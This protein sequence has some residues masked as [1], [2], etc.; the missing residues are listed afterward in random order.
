VLRKW[1][2]ANFKS[3]NARTELDLAPITVLAG[4][5][6]SGKSTII[7]SILLLKQ[8]I[9]YVPTTR[10]IGLNGP[11]LKLGRFDDI[12][13]ISSRDNSVQLSW[14]IDDISKYRPGG[15]ALESYLNAFGEFSLQ[16]ASFSISFG[17]DSGASSEGEELTV[18]RSSA[19]LRQL[20]PAL[21]STQLNLT[22]LSVEENKVVSHSSDISL[23]R[24][25]PRGETALNPINDS[26]IAQARRSLAFYVDHLDDS[27]RNELLQQRPE[28]RIVGA[29]SR[30]FFP[31]QVG[32]VYNKNKDLARKLAASISSLQASSVY[33]YDGEV[34]KAVVPAAFTQFVIS[35]IQ[36]SIVSQDNPSVLGSGGYTSDRARALLEAFDIRDMTIMELLESLH[37]VTRRID[38]R[39]RTLI[40]NAL[41]E[42]QEELE[43]KFLELASLGAETGLDLNLPGAILHSVEQATTFFRHSI[44]YLGPLRDEP[45]PVYPLEALVNPTDV[46][47]RG[48]HT[49]AVLDLHRDRQ[50]RYIRSADVHNPIDA[51]ERLATLHAAVVDWLSYLGVAESVRTTDLGKIGHQLQVR[52]GDN[53]K[54]HDLTNVG[55]G[56]SQLLPI[57]VMALLAPSPSFLIFEQP[58]LHLHPKV[59][60]RLADFFLSLGLSGR[61]CLLETH[62]EYL[63]ERLR[64]RIAEADADSLKDKIM[65]YFTEKKAGN[66]TCIPVEL[67]RYGAIRNWPTDFFDQ[68][69]TETEQL[70]T[71]AQRKLD[72]ER[73]KGAEKR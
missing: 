52:T 62:S 59:Q 26:V 28:S 45:R 46:G 61:Q 65:I 13:N 73:E 21:Q 42:T 41:A 27:S 64:L 30:H 67:S 72:R 18:S 33:Y 60:A 54:E 5:N 8:T 38:P 25:R 19:E 3:F 71:A 11:L 7:Q 1:A 58:E 51:V 24:A 57:I 29:S 66:S 39:L 23:V 10:A 56:V 36:N 44:R 43:L 17:V 40:R 53:S 6:S 63:V 49:A 48:E 37:L 20:Q 35:T 9:E 14:L 55:V 70:L 12:K 15:V 47:Y 31:Y 4:A 2:L 68:T 32:V 69:Q 50:V 22:F 34:R 16:E